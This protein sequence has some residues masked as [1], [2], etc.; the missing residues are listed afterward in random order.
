LFTRRGFFP[1]FSNNDYLD[2]IR[3]GL[4]VQPELPAAQLFCH[5]LNRLGPNKRLGSPFDDDLAEEDIYE[6]VSAF[7]GKRVLS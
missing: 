1:A 5:L 6:E 4:A 3:T 7:A 2:F